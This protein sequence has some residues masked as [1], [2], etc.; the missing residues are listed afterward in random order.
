M[1]G[2]LKK[3]VQKLPDTIGNN[4]YVYV[5]SIRKQYTKVKDLFTNVIKLFIYS[6]KRVTPAFQKSYLLHDA[7][8]QSTT[9]Y[10]KVTTNFEIKYL[11]LVS[12]YIMCG[13]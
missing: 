7:F 10:N 6:Q 3:Y 9:S 8:V 11:T 4:H 1:F 12:L 13:I 2:I 5:N